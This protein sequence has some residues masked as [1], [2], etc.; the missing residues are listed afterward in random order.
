MKIGISGSHGTGKTSL[1][2]K[3]SKQFDLPLITEVAR[4]VNIMLLKGNQYCQAQ[5]DILIK[6]IEEEG[7]YQSFVSDRTVIDNLAYFI[8]ICSHIVSI[9][10]IKWYVNE[11]RNHI[12]VYDKIYYLPIKFE[13]VDNGFRFTEMSVQKNIDDII[14]SILYLWNIEFEEIKNGNRK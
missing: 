10:E 7:K 5:R 4:D 13:L 11:A 14:R 1:A 6:Q 3:L 8:S 9:K 12:S 2:K